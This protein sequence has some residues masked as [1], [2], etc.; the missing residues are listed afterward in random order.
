[1]TLASLDMA[2]LPSLRYYEAPLHMKANGGTFLIDDFG[3]QHVA[4]DQLLNRWIIPLEHR[5]DFLTLHNGQ[6]IEVPFLLMLIIATNL[7][8][9]EVTVPAFLRRLGYRT[10]LSAP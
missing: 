10:R 5:I 7:N 4:P 6:K 1:M 9:S 8:P 3:R 2:Y